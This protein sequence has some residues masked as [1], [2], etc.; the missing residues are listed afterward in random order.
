[1]TLKAVAEAAGVSVSAVSYALR[2]APN[3]PAETAA[4]VREAAERLGYRP[5]AR[6]GEL[7][8]HIRKARPLARAEPLALVHLEGKPDA[9]S[10]NSFARRVEMAARVRAEARGYRLDTFWLSQVRGN[11]RR[12]ADILE[13][14]GISG[15]LFAPTVDERR[16]ELKWPWE[17]FAMAV[18][19]MTEWSVPLSRAGH[20]H[21]EAM[22][23]ALERLATVGARRPVALLE[24]ATNERAHRGWQAAWLAYGPKDAARRLW[25]RRDQKP[26]ELADWLAGMKVDGII[27]DGGTLA[28][29]VRETGWAGPAERVV[30]LSWQPGAGMAGIDQGYDAIAEHAVDLVVTQLQRNERGLPSPPH[31][32]LFPG[33]WREAE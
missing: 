15:V 21:Y 7:M 30:S 3:I 12:L 28:Q 5:N 4:R 31:M 19:G 17:K 26:G 6:V 13:A 18:V 20:H 27:A 33:R 9:T 8:A 2:G 23:T 29:I 32:L 11:A 24:A 1:M 14:R 16:I 25:L 22:R 10:V